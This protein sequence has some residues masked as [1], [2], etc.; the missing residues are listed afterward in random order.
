M[1]AGSQAVGGRELGL[2][3]HHDGLSQRGLALSWMLE[4]HLLGG[5]VRDVPLLHA[6]F[7]LHRLARPE[8]TLGVEV[9]P[10]LLDGLGCRHLRDQLLPEPVASPVG[11]DEGGCTGQHHVHL[12]YQD[13]LEGLALNHSPEA[14]DVMSRLL[15]L[16]QILRK[17]LL[18]TKWLMLR[19]W[20]QCPCFVL[21]IGVGLGLIQALPIG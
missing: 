9:S 4:P 5:V 11:L 21:E 20:T 8:E 13:V 6:H 18:G 15:V 1:G 19:F 17:A 10:G 14:W 16:V 3:A 12:I 2:F 7:F